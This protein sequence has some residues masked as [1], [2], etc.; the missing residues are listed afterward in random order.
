MNTPKKKYVVWYNGGAGGFFVSWLIQVCLFPNDLSL[1]LKV[2]PL[3]ITNNSKQWRKYEK[4]P[5]NVNV[6][7]NSFYPISYYKVDSDVLTQ[8]TL[9]S[10]RHDGSSIYDLFHCRIKL[11]LV[12]YVYQ[13][14]HVNTTDFNWINKNKDKFDL[15]DQELV[16][17]ATDI[18]FDLKKNIFVCA[19]EK[20][21][22][23]AAHSKKFRYY[24]SNLNEILYRNK[25]LKI[26]NIDSIWKNYYVKELEKIL[27]TTLNINQIYAVKTLVDRYMDIMPLNMKQYFYAD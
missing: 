4:T 19:P 26:F 9:D 11:F 20:Y 10:V 5:K 25:D 7:C 2:F 27:G 13:S 23:L 15:Y 21:I 6:L 24:E 16:K 12:N 17:N 18:L 1:S 3:K 22:E 14:G 8:Q